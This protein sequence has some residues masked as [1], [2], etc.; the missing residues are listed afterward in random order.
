MTVDHRPRRRPE[1]RLLGK[2]DVPANQ[3]E[4]RGMSGAQVIRNPPKALQKVSQKGVLRRG[5]REKRITRH[6][7]PDT[8]RKGK[9]IDQAA[10]IVRT[11][12]VA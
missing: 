3:L 8:G 5:L 4:R 1:E 6:I 10:I 9:V 12:H 2:F 11:F 7:E